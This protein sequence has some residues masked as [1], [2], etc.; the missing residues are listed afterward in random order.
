MPDT[1]AEADRKS[2]S[3]TYCDVLGHCTVHR[4]GERAWRNNNP[5][6]ISSKGPFARSQGAIGDDGTFAIFPDPETGRRAMER[7]L[8]GQEYQKL[9]VGD[10]IKRWSLGNKPPAAEK[11][12]GLKSYRRNVQHW[13]GISLDEPMSDLSQQQIRQLRK[14]ME[15]Q[16]GQATGTVKR[17]PRGPR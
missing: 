10:A 2:L 8:R 12:A 3:V 17:L 11:K 13:T 15:R 16:E 7:L 6:N 1:R 5:G 9:T 4:G 14:A